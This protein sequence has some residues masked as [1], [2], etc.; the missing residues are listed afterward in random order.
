VG[1]GV[2]VGA[3]VGVGVA[4]EELV[5]TG[6]GV[7]VGDGVEVGDGVGVGVGD[8]VGVGAK[9]LMFIVTFPASKA[10]RL[11][12]YDIENPA[13]SNCCVSMLAINTLVLL[14]YHFSVDP[15]QTKVGA[16]VD[17]LKVTVEVLSGV[18]T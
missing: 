17:V 7:S 15:S 2:D 5:G 10:I 16:N 18:L 9:L 6:V 13:G 8:G 4:V 1:V 11:S 12:M 3:G 14:P